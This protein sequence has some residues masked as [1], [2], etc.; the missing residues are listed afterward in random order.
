MFHKG[1]RVVEELGT[2]FW[3]FFEDIKNVTVGEEARDT[4][5]VNTKPRR[6]FEEPAAEAVV[7]GVSATGSSL[8]RRSISGS[9]VVR[10]AVSM[11]SLGCHSRE[12]SELGGKGLRSVPEVS[13]NSYF[14]V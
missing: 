7:S 2:Q 8:Q 3:S 14:I 4:T 12:K 9:S 6:R 13:S 1:R 10:P 11:S 5:L